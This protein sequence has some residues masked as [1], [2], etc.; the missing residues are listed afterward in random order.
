MTLMTLIA[1]L[2]V[3]AVEFYF[4]WG[5]Q[6]RSFDWFII[7]QEK[8]EIQFGENKFFQS[9]AGVAL[10]LLIPVIILWFGINLFSGYWYLLILLLVSCAV[11]FLSLGPIS[12]ADSLKSYLEAMERG[13]D[14]AGYLSLQKVSK[15]E[16]VLNSDDLVRN[17][18]R[19]IFVESLSRYFGVIFWFIFLG[20][21][22]A[23]LYRLAH[24]YYCQC[25]ELESKESESKELESKEL[26]S[27]ELESKENEH[28]QLMTSLLYWIDW[29][30]ARLTSL[31][32]LLTGDFVNGFSR[33][34]DYF[35]DLSSDNKQLITETGIAALGVHLGMAGD[36]VKEN[37]KAIALVDRTLI[38]YLVVIAALTPL[39][40]W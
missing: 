22:G 7:L 5:T 3:M 6:Y 23:L 25:K 10:I 17:A 35:T 8:L 16:D 36:D 34:K 14:E 29:L 12:L 11:L 37:H 19:V 28:L 30:P 38:I 13:D 21:Y 15:L 18:T 2:I 9:W 31:L 1:V 39:S 32:F 33:V 4:K 27:K 26:E 20:P 40:F 24:L